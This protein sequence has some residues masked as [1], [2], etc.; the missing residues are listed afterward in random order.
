MKKLYD[1]M[2]EHY[3][4]KDK[5]LNLVSIT[6]ANKMKNSLHIFLWKYGNNLVG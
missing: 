3:N 1:W 2:Q 5:C 6:Y 4:I